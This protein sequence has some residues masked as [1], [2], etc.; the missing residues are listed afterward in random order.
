MNLIDHMKAKPLSDSF[1]SSKPETRLRL[2]YLTTKYPNVSH[3]FIRRELREIERRGHTLLRIAIRK[4]D[5]AL[6]DPLDREENEKTIH[7][8]S[9]PAWSHLLRLLWVIISRP[10]KF[11]DALR[12][13]IKMGLSSDRGVIKHLAYLAEACSTLVILRRNV[14]AHV[15]V[16]FGTNATAVARLIRRCGG[17]S[18]SFTV[19]GP[20]EFDA[21]IA[22]DLK[23]KIADAAFVIAITDF[24]SA[25]L[26]RW[27]DP[28][29]WPKIHV[30]GCTVGDDFFD[31]LKPVDPHNRTF[32]CVGRLTP[33]KGQLTL[34]DAFAELINGGV[35]ARLIFVGDGELRK[36]IE[37][38]V[39]AA[40]LSDYVTIT[41]FV[42]EAQVRHYITSSRALVLPSFAE[43][44][45]MVIMEAFA[46]GRTVV[47]TYIAGI[48]EL[49]RAPENGW[50]V[51]AGSVSRLSEALLEVLSTPAEKLSKMAMRGRDLT[52]AHHRTVS[53]CNRLETLLSHYV[54]PINSKT[55][56][57]VLAIS[58]GGG[59]WV[60]L[61]RLRPAFDDQKV[62]YATISADYAKDIPNRRFFV[63][64]DATRWNK[65]GL[66]LMAV[67]LFLII[68]R[69]RP[70]VIISTGAACGYFAF[71]FGK[72]IG[73]RTIWIDSIANVE[74]VSMTGKLVKPYADLWLTQWPELS[75]EG[76]PE[77][78]G[79]VL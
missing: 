10:L 79:A 8:L 45:P 9:L 17:P 44:L 35:E 74:E 40:R 19:H 57:R 59:H 61:L 26:K 54:K 69:F 53:E 68:F 66:I 14:I 27:S 33:Q 11:G 75:K 38:K 34:I 64:N 1:I 42:S 28:I 24:C 18:Y 41:G 51:P 23:G 20:T 22:F 67:R 7:L 30:V 31:A 3:T 25:Q 5:A 48:P 52:F 39:I 21:A 73:A 55:K 46:L 56:K 65:I 50:L 4:S 29:H 76:G 62:A 2:A 58:S 71:R 77:Y 13:A 49:V 43:G 15:H 78:L 32:V 60:Q 36:A 16:H 72:L 47:S 63:I 70:E 12:T 37:E 6:F